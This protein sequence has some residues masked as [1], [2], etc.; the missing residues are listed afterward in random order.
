MKQRSEDALR[1]VVPDVLDEETEESE[2]PWRDDE[3]AP[4]R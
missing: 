1:E 4:F 3:H 2:E